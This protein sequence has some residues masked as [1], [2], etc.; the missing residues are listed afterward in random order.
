[1]CRAGPY[2]WC[3]KFCSLPDRILEIKVP[4]ELSVVASK[5]EPIWLVKKV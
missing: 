4:K 2:H 3:P 1:L 5:V